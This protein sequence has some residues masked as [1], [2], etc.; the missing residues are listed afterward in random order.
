M[1][2]WHQFTIITVW[3]WN[4]FQLQH[5]LFGSTLSSGPRKCFAC[6]INQ[7]SSSNS[8]RVTTC[9]VCVWLVVFYC[10]FR[11]SLLYVVCV[12]FSCW[13]LVSSLYRSPVFLQSSRSFP[14]HSP[15]PRLPTSPAASTRSQCLPVLTH[16]VLTQSSIRHTVCSPVCSSF[17]TSSSFSVCY[18]VSHLCF[19]VKL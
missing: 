14:P 4:Y 9:G 15:V 16:L 13:F 7:I 11:F 3:K 8:R 18:F 19:V 5:Y 12:N 1:H 10:C 6:C 17:F 2:R